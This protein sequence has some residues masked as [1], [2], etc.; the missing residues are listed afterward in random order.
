M[1]PGHPLVS[2]LVVTS[3]HV[4]SHPIPSGCLL[5]TG[6][7][8]TPPT[9]FKVLSSNICQNLRA[10]ISYLSDILKIPGKNAEYQIIHACSSSSMG[11]G[12]QYH[13]EPCIGWLVVTSSPKKKQEKRE[14][15][16]SCVLKQT[17][18][19]AVFY[20]SSVGGS[21]LCSCVRVI[22]FA[23][24]NK[25]TSGHFVEKNLLRSSSLSA[26][27][28]TIS[29]NTWK[30]AFSEEFPTSLNCKSTGLFDAILEIRRKQVYTC[31][32][33]RI[34]A[35]K[36]N[37]WFQDTCWTSVSVPKP[38]EKIRKGVEICFVLWKDFKVQSKLVFLCC[39]HLSNNPLLELSEGTFVHL[40][41][42]KYL[43]VPN[44]K[45]HEKGGFLRLRHQVGKKL[46]NVGSKLDW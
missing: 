15:L 22:V 46:W 27:S 8:E 28:P 26:I 34:P 17:C 44:H 11:D 9:P 25:P 23:L 12:G 5:V 32:R 24:P 4:P 14:V 43:W 7:Q 39:R 20:F 6:Y 13:R 1:S 10:A 42:L 41:K 21:I 31:N 2:C 40:S 35:L 36:R 37:T 3:F 33:E 30:K 18:C 29:W 45:N 19:P 16:H 38:F